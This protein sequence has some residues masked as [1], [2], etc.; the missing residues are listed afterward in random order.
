MDQRGFQV[1]WTVSSSAQVN[2]YALYIYWATWAIY[3]VVLRKKK[4]KKKEE[5]RKEEAL[6]RSD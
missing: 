1:L 3:F 5:R 2:V 4:K 6:G